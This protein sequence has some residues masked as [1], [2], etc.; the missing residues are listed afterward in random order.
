[1][2]GI[3][4]HAAV[5]ITHEFCSVLDTTSWIF[6]ENLFVYPELAKW[7][8]TL[9]TISVA[10]FKQ[11]QYTAYSSGMGLMVLSG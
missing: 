9:S 8:A 10:H 4:F 2:P 1:M 5:S 7:Q 6:T 11:V 3:H